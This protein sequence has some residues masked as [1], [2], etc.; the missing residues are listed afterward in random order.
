ML[1]AKRIAVLTIK[2][3]FG[4][5]TGAAFIERAK[6]LGA[7]VVSE[8]VYPLGEKEFSPY[9]TK[10]KEQNVD[11]IYHTSYY[12]EGALIS[13]K[14]RQ[15]GITAKLEGTEGID[16]PK[17]LELAG[18]AAEGVTFTT[19]LN[20]DDPR[21]EVQG[22]LKKY[23]AKTGT[24]ADM[25]GASAY[26]AVKILARGIEQAGTDPKAICAALT[27]LRDYPAITGKISRFTKGEVTKPVQI[28]VVKD[29]KIRSLTTI[30][31]PEVITPP[32]Q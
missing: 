11:L 21:P 16:S 4:A 18:P 8:Q 28:Q 9:L 12:N 20:R 24:D 7:E 22:F 5:T 27:N 19:N 23:K 6:K 25:V 30:D 13:R 1:K 31:N 2:N 32:V 26:D 15:L 10:I 17:F 3:D 14:A 29:G